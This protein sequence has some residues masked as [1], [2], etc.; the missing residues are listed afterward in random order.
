MR[1]VRREPRTGDGVIT[2]VLV[3]LLR[4]PPLVRYFE[5]KTAEDLADITRS[6]KEAHYA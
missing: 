1:R 5:H 6:F 3:S 4:L 2:A